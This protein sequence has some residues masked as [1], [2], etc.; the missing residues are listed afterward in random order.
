[1]YPMITP[2]TELFTVRN[3]L[4]NKR[5]YMVNSPEDRLL[6]VSHRLYAELIRADGTHPIIEDVAVLDDLVLT[7]KRYLGNGIMRHQ[8][9]PIKKPRNWFAGKLY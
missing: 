1:M 6:E 9:L 5:L 3:K 7:R 8:L 2:E 4:G